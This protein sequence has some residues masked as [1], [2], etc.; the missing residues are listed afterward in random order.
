MRINKWVA[1]S[2]GLSRRAADQAI[3]DGRVQVNTTT[4]ELG[5]QVSL[6][7]TITLD[8]K[9]L[10][11]PEQLATI[12]LNKPVGYVCSRAK[13][14]N[15]TIYELLPAS[16]RELKPVGRLDKDS[17]GLLLLT[18]DGQI[19]NELTHPSKKKL[20]VYEVS[21]NRPLS[22]TDQ[23]KIEQGIQVENYTS[24]LQ[25]KELAGHTHFLVSLMEGKNR[26][27][28]RTFGALEYRVAKL[29]RISF[30]SYTLG[31]L[32][33]GSFQRLTVPE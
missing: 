4:A 32:P 16:F 19:A 11:P 2:S 3:K 17:S 21:L 5:Q 1:V 15:K 23:K 22:A 20:K 26:Q 18:N 25:L 29:H 9:T 13:Q 31:E 12:M 24:Y 33:S 6:S 28:R 27:I 8:Q 14:G 10:R 7:D 30:G